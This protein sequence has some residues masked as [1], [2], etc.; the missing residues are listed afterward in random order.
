[1]IKAIIF[2]M[3][4]LM[5]DTEP[6]F[7]EATNKLL[8]KYGKKLSEKEYCSFVGISDELF[9]TKMKFKFELRERVDYYIKARVE[10]VNEL[11]ERKL[12][13]MPGFV[14]LY[15]NLKR[16]GMKI[17]I[18]SSSHRSNVTKIVNKLR[19]QSDY[20]IYSEMVEQQ[21]PNPEIYKKAVEGLNLETSECIAIEDS[22]VG[23]NAAIAAGLKCICI[24]NSYTKDQD[25]SKATMKLNSLNDVNDEVLNSL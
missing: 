23:V 3:D 12:A 7:M 18:A 4:G 15:N 20:T 24:P 19:I 2:D 14:N 16:K 1:M 22:R 21:K 25:H 9:W 13:P 8:R 11:I 6:L 17:A 5:V 10:L